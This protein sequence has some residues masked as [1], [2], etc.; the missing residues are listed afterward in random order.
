MSYLKHLNL[1][2]KKQFIIILILTI[3]LS[4]LEVIGI[5]L[6]IPIIQFLQE[7]ESKEFGLLINLKNIINSMNFKFNLNTMITILCLLF[8]FK[9]SIAILL[10]FLTIK[11]TIKMQNN[12]RLQIFD[13]L[14]FSNIN[15]IYNTKQG[16]LI[17][18]LNEHTTKASNVFNALIQQIVMALTSISFLCLMFY[19]NIILTILTIS[20]LFFLFPLTKYIAR[21]SNKFAQD[22]T[23][24][25]EDSNQFGLETIRSKKLIN[26]MNWQHERLINYKIIISKIYKSFFGVAFWSNSPP[27]FIQPIIV[28]FISTI[29]IFSVKLNIPLAMLTAF[30][31]TLIRILP[32]IQNFLTYHTEIKSDLPSFNRVNSIIDELNKNKE[33]NGKEILQGRINQICFE[34]VS[35]DYENNIKIFRDISFSLEV[36]KS[37]AL[38]GS[39]GSG[40]TTIADLILGMQKPNSGKVMINGISTSNIDLHYLRDRVGYV[41]QEPFL[42]NDTIENNLTMGL[43]TRPTEEEIIEVCKLTGCWEF[44]SK[45]S[46]K[47][48]TIAGDVG[49]KFSGGQKQKI[50]L[51]RTLL[52]KPEFLILDEATSALDR[53]SEE[54]IQKLLSLLKKT[55]MTILIIAHRA[56][57]IKQVNNLIEIKEGYLKQASKKDITKILKDKL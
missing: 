18:S 8:L 5:S 29:I 32:S 30:I 3:I 7:G 25:I 20:I 35:F 2:D 10:R 42:F 15:Y 22:F 23:L 44:I 28:F 57:T 52:R 16:I 21:Q 53:K 54:D 31:L 37:T 13:G 4:F 36:G 12:L 48:K 40:K 11:L 6:F 50:V 1:I 34:K 26:S 27:L 38:I 41:S 49:A 24:D 45:R 33:N 14:L 51:A 39:S 47:L 9:A 19:L 56:S 55:N 43:K 17:A 46:L